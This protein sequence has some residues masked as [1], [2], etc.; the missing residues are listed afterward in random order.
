MGILNRMLRQKTEKFYDIF[1]FEEMVPTSF[2]F[3][4]SVKVTG[5]LS[6]SRWGNKRRTFDDDEGWRDKIQCRAFMKG[7]FDGSRI[8]FFPPV[9][10]NYATQNFKSL[11]LLRQKL[12]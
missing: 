7:N 9:M 6:L 5:V 11:N 1:F 12:P 8:S 2:H 3:S 4:A 10:K